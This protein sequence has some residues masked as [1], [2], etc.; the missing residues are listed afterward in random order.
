MH[1]VEKVEHG[2]GRVSDP[3]VLPP[4]VFEYALS[5][6]QPEALE[7]RT[8]PATLIDAD[9]ET[10][11]YEKART[12]GNAS[13]RFAAS[14]YLASLHHPESV[15]FI[16][17][18]DQAAQDEI[19]DDFF[20]DY[21]GHIGMSDAETAR[22]LF[23]A[24]RSM[25]STADRVLMM[26][27]YL[28]FWAGSYRPGRRPQ[29]FGQNDSLLVQA[30]GRNTFTDAQLPTVVAEYK[31]AGSDEAMFEGFLADEHF[32]EGASNRVL[33]DAV[34]DVL[35]DETHIIEPIMQWEVSYSLWNRYPE[36]FAAHRSG[37]H[38]LWPQSGFYPTY[39]V[40]ADSI[41]VM[42]ER[43]LLNPL[44]LAHP[45]MTIRALGILAR[46][47]VQADALDVSV[48]FD[49]ASTQLQVRDRWQ[50][51]L[52]EFPTRAHHTLTNRVRF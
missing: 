14:S 51:M 45:D 26:G 3:T 13:V 31:K 1:Y 21:D 24:K 39:D 41:A 28:N 42:R 37:I 44:E 11:R 46:Q 30:F 5:L 35:Q 32:D 47:G 8:T 10:L 29:N 38:T 6:R 12:I 22:R 17:D 25:I 40:K 34:A 43:G 19:F 16:G 50:W 4:A 27:S 52:R 36:L 7:R 33:A 15:E 2:R 48:P 49:A 20:A 23:E 9:S 18:M